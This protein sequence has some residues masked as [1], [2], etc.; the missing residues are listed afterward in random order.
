MD[1]LCRCLDVLP[2][3][4][5]RADRRRLCCRRGGVPQFGD[6]IRD[7][8]I[9]VGDLVEI[10]IPAAAE[11]LGLKFHRSVTNG[12]WVRGVPRDEAEMAVEYV[13]D[14]GFSACIRDCAAQNERPPVHGVTRAA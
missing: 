4:R 3:G 9:H 6:N 7:G 13:R 10:A 14:Y 8:E 12:A 2:T 1:F 5:D 11:A